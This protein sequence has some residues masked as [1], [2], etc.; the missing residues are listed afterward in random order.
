MSTSYFSSR[1]HKTVLLSYQNED[2]EIDEVLAPLIQEIWKANI[3]TMMC[4]Q[5]TE[6]GI[7][8]I[9][10]DSMDDFLKFLNIVVKYEEGANTFYNRVNYQLTGEISKP[11]WEYHVTLLDIEA[12]AEQR[13]DGGEKVDFDAT[14]GISFPYDDLPIILKRI[15]AFNRSS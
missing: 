8:W 9:E 7:A 13:R 5:E 14:V 4:C 12:A 6:S 1:P 15:Q 10:F 2:V 3:A 11:L